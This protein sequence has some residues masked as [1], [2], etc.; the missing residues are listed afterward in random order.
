MTEPL[1]ERDRWIGER[2]YSAGFIDGQAYRR[3][4]DKHGGPQVNV[5]TFDDWL[6]SRHCAGTNKDY[7]EA[8]APKC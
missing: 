8:E 5:P 1:T 4:V 2:A 7:I 3:L 6:E